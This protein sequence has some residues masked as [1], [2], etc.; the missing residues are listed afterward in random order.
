MVEAGA[1]LCRH[2]QTVALLENE[3]RRSL[4]GGAAVVE[5]DVAN[6]AADIWVAW[7]DAPMPGDEALTGL[8][9]C[10]SALASTSGAPVRCLHARVSW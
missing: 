9:D 3:L 7:R 1:Q 5:V 2:A 8:P 4:P 6:T 10:P